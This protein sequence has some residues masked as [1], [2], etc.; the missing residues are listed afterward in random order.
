MALHCWLSAYLLFAAAFEQH[1]KD[2]HAHLIADKS[3]NAVAQSYG[4]SFDTSR[5]TQ[6][7]LCR[8]IISSL[9]QLRGHLGRHQRELSLFALPT[10]VSEDEGSNKDS[11]NEGSASPSDS[12][13]NEERVITYD[14]IFAFLDCPFTTQNRT[15]WE[16]HSLSHFKDEEPPHSVNCPFCRW[17]SRLSNGHLAWSFKLQHIETHLKSGWKM[18]QGR[19]DL[20]LH[21]FLREQGLLDESHAE[22][23][24]GI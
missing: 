1:F 3:L 13:V 9:K 22:E 11:D 8:V 10:S 15:D 4:S 7:P 2:V 23:Q 20:E 12:V 14:C 18:S 21:L 19:P 17:K 6:C 5:G 24:Q 16:D